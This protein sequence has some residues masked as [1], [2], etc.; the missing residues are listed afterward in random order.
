MPSITSYINPNARHNVILSPHEIDGVH[1]VDV[2]RELSS[3]LQ[4]KAHNPNLPSFAE[5]AINKIISGNIQTD[6]D[7]RYVA[8]KNI[9]ILFEPQLAL[10][11]SMFFRSNSQNQTLIVCAEGTIN[12]NQFAFCGNEDFTVDLSDL[13]IQRIN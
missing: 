6:S 2:G 4:G 11:L 9:G 3:A 13:N 7:V 10:N 12:N 5:N 1:Y 8:I